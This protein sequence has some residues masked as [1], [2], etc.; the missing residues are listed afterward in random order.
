MRQLVQELGA[1]L[2]AAFDL[3]LPYD[4]NIDS[5][6]ADSI[7]DRTAGGGR[8]Q[9]A[10][11]TS[12]REQSTLISK[13][14]TDDMRRELRQTIAQGAS[15]TM[16]CISPE[17][18]LMIQQYYAL[19]RQQSSSYGQPSSVMDPGS[20]TVASLLRMAT[21]CARLH[22]RNDV[23]TMPDAVLAIYLLQE[24]LRAKVSLAVL[25]VYSI[26]E[27]VLQCIKAACIGVDSTAGL[28]HW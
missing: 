7:L 10:A 1:G 5:H 19:L 27:N 23:T 28:K 20:Y 18:M 2:F 12:G 4:Q 22:M 8:L 6:D 15:L 25:L 11:S 14:R 24:S 13:R 21:A 3:A 26:D 16:P 9:S 17:A